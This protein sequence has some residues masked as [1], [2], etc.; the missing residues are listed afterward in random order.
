M[1]LKPQDVLIILKLVVKRGQNWSYA[2]IANELAMSPSEVH[3]GIRRAKVG[4]LFSEP[5]RRP[6]IANL[7]EFVVHG[8]KYA[9][10]VV[11]GTRTRGIVTA[12]AAKPLSKVIVQEDTLPPVWPD[13]QGET[14][15]ISFSP[16][17][18]SVPQAAARD[19]KLYEL[20]TIVDA[21]REGRAR[22]R[23][24]AVKEL[25]RQLLTQVEE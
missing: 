4:R 12:Y 21:F 7:E 3:A 20:L 2:S 1:V 13:P 10:P 17:Y 11:H 16:L 5:D 24:I 25:H 14:L 18:K 9:F 22:E 6:V 15:G 23:E 19:R 8:V